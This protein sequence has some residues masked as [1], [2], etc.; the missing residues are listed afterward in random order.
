MLRS[1]IEQI[2]IPIISFNE[3][4]EILPLVNELLTEQDSVTFQLKYDALDKMIAN[5][6]GLT[7]ADYE[8]VCNL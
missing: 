8:I 3:Q 6:F 2:P 7:E 4:K 5:L 1:H